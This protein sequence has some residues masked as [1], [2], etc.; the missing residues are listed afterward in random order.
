MRL[1]KIINGLTTYYYRLYLKM[2]GSK[3]GRDTRFCGR[4]SFCMEKPSNLIIGDGVAMTGGCFIN[5]LG[6]LRGSA[7][8]LDGGGLLK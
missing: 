5:P 6:A 8:R 1:R 7:I 4:L 3:V 2:K